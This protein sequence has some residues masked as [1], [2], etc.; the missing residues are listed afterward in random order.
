MEHDGCSQGPHHCSVLVEC[1]RG[2]S[3]STQEAGRSG[4]GHMRVHVRN[5]TSWSTTV[6]PVR[7]LLLLP[8]APTTSFP[9]SP[10]VKFLQKHPSEPTCRIQQEHL[11]KMHSLLMTAN[12]IVMKGIN[13]SGH[14]Q[15]FSSLKKSFNGSLWWN[16]RGTKTQKLTTEGPLAYTGCGLT[17]KLKWGLTDRLNWQ[18][19][20][21]GSDRGKK[22]HRLFPDLW[23]HLQVY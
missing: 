1:W 8:S 21:V 9:A 19:R 7:R 2:I 15:E 13:R 12:E 18:T 5:S 20:V 23:L 22:S 16:C 6:D 17:Q 14:F 3:W 10:L 11:W 4:P